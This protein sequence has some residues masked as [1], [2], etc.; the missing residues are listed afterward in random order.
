MEGKVK[1]MKDHI[2][3]GYK[4]ITRK[5]N[6][7]T[8]SRKLNYPSESTMAKTI[9]NKK[10]HP[11]KCWGCG[12]EQ[13]FREFPKKGNKRSTTHNL[14]E[15]TIVDDVGKSIPRI[16]AALDNRQ[17]NH[18]ST[19]IEVKG[20]IVEVPIS[21]LIDLGSNYSYMSTNVIER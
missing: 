15:A 5:S 7:P 14:Q 2:K 1:Y 17:A 20:M 19:M 10:K 13:L 18:L 4:T 21:I 9:G 12:E 8:Y 16:Y 11:I 3:N 6:P